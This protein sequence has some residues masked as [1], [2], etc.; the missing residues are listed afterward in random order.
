[1][2]L[3]RRL[4]GVT[5]TLDG[6]VGRAWGW[7]CACGGGDDR[8]ADATF[9]A[10]LALTPFP[11]IVELPA[12]PDDDDD[13]AGLPR[14][15]PAAGAVEAPPLALFSNA[16]ARAEALGPLEAP[17]IAAALPVAEFVLG[18]GAVEEDAGRW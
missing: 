15:V 3:P 7:A 12:Y 17:M 9:V 5:A 2:P 10:G 11:P 14:C 1:M 16:A 13:P 6:D 8:C 4:S 18:A